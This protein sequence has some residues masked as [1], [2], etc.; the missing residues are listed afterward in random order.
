MWLSHWPNKASV[1]IQ[2]FGSK[3]FTL[4][5]YEMLHYGGGEMLARPLRAL[6]QSKGLK[7]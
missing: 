7:S 4:D 5:H 3:V 6:V 2:K 1:Q